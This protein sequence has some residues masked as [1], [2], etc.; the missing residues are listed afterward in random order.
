MHFG[1]RAFDVPSGG[2]LLLLP[3]LVTWA[4]DIGAYACGRTFG[5]HKLIPS[6]SPGKTI[7]GAVGGLVASVLVAW[8]YSRFLLRP[9]A[10]LGFRWEPIGVIAFGALVSVA[11][12]IG[13]LAES[14]MKRE[15]GEVLPT[16]QL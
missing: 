3:L 8:L 1:G 11:A 7:E 2:L 13:D 15:G 6:V 4:S 14:L 10:H 16:F 12:Q 9:D 5:R